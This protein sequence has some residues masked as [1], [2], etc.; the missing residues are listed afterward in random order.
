MDYIIDGYNY[1]GRVL[2]PDSSWRDD[3]EE[4]R[5]TLNGLIGASSRPERDNVLIVYDGRFGVYDRDAPAFVRFSRD[6]SAD[7]LI[8]RMV[9]KIPE[10]KRDNA[11]VVTSDRELTAT[12]RGLGVEVKSAEEF[13]SLLGGWSRTARTRDEHRKP[14]PGSPAAKEITDE[15]S[16]IWGTEEENGD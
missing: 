1:I 2:Y 5:R 14:D 10:T 16:R 9:E 7:D 3:L 8:V 11:A 15:L 12:V 4:A 6:E 13:S